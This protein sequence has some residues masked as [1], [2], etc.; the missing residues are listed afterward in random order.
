MAD[1]PAHNG[2]G[3]GVQYGQGPVNAFISIHPEPATLR[4]ATGADT[5]YVDSLQKRFAA[6][7]GFLPKIAIQNY[8]DAGCVHLAVENDDP[9]GYILSKRRL[10]WQPQLRSITQACVAMDA[11]RRH[12][13]LALLEKIS[14]EARADGVVALQACCAVGL[15]SNE[16][17]AAAGF[18]PIVHMTP[19]NVRGREVICWRKPLV[20]KLPLWFAFPPARAGW[21][22]ATPK[23]VRDTQR[24]AAALAE[25]RRYITTGAKAQ[26]REARPQDRT[27]K[28][29]RTRLREVRTGPELQ[30]GPGLET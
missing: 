14:A 29:A 8:I 10:V 18:R 16:F 4:I 24:D 13:G 6:A 17:W 22:A 28:T 9:A 5:T 12:H 19:S 27:G 25:A 30:N 20:K 2:P 7:V 11:Q 26:A 1:D 15:E 3:T 21:R 23:S